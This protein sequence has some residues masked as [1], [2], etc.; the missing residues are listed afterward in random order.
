MDMPFPLNVEWLFRW[1]HIDVLN[2]DDNKTSALTN[3]G[4]ISSSRCNCM[5][6]LLYGLVSGM[7]RLPW[8]AR[9]EQRA[10][11]ALRCER[12]APVWPR[13]P[14]C[15][16]TRAPPRFLHTTACSRQSCF[17][18]LL[19]CESLRDDIQVRAAIERQGNAHRT[20]WA[21]LLD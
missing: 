11:A 14:S 19:G 6:L 13:T 15:P 2:N 18:T 16:R 12:A 4:Y 10:G 7:R 17:D 5:I 21:S 8:A 3:N 9:S 20:R 1:N